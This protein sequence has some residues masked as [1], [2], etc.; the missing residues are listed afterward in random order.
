MLTL[1]ARDHIYQLDVLAYIN[2]IYLWLKAEKPQALLRN[3]SKIAKRL[4]LTMDELAT[5]VYD[6][7]TEH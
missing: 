2:N 4:G 1:S 6:H 7:K 5:I 3:G